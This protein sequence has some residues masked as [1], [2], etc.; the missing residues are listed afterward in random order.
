M[1]HVKKF[2]NYIFIVEI[3][4]RIIIFFNYKIWEWFM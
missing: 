4:L 1:I 3:I 2:T